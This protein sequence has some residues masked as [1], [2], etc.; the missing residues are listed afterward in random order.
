MVADGNGYRRTT[1][2]NHERICRDGSAG[3]S[4]GNTSGSSR[5]NGG[6]VI[7]AGLGISRVK[8]VRGWGKL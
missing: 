1:L 4:G 5:V 7:P 3:E 8:V 2:A 6:V